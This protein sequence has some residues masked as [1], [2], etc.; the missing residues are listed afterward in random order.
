MVVFFQIICY[1]LT[2]SNLMLRK[3]ASSRKCTGM[4]LIPEKPC[5][6]GLHG[7]GGQLLKAQQKRFTQMKKKTQVSELVLKCIKSNKST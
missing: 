3:N 1:T 7:G 4:G 5:D 2:M 6:T